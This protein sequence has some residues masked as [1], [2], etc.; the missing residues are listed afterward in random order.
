[1]A[2]LPGPEEVTGTR[3]VLIKQTHLPWFLINGGGAGPRCQHL[4]LGGAAEKRPHSL[5]VRARP[6]GE[7]REGSWVPEAEP[8]LESVCLNLSV[9]RVRARLRRPPLCVSSR[10][11][12]LEE[13]PPQ[14]HQEVSPSSCGSRWMPLGPCGPLRPSLPTGW[15]LP[16]PPGTRG[17]AKA[18][19]LVPFQ[20]PE[21][22]PAGS[23]ADS[24]APL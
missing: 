19:D 10:R 6:G 8:R 14:W 23:E 9:R 22:T 13:Q 21:E 18:Q 20:S 3:C 16:P 1:M 17:E 4:T 7:Q 5:G 11:W 2:S 24:V 15:P 12:A